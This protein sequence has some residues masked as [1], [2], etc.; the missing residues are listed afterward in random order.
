MEATIFK[1]QKTGLGFSEWYSRLG[2]HLE[3]Y[4]LAHNLNF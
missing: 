1:M 4:R 2:G 3:G